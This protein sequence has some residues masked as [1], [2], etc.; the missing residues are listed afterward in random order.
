MKQKSEILSYG[1]DSLR[2]LSCINGNYDWFS[3]LIVFVWSKFDSNIDV[4][5]YLFFIFFSLL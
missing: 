3:K 4:S 1:E 2:Q 5:F